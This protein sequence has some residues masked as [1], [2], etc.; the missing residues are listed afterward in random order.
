ML[1]ALDVLGS[2]SSNIPL[3]G[4]PSLDPGLD[5]AGHTFIDFGDDQLTV[6]RPHPMIDA[7]LRLERLRRELVDPSCAVILLDVVLGHGAHP[8][9]ATEL[10]DAIQGAPVPVVVSLVGTRDDPQ[11]RDGQADRLADA[12]AIV[13]ASNAAATREALSLIGT[14]S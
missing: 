7:T 4:Q 11:G 1:I 5:S 9:P 2:I 6:G 12:G 13:H 8:D 14:A 10:A 3:P